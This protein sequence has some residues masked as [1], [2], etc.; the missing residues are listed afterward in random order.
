MKNPCRAKDTSL[1]S[2][3]ASDDKTFYDIESRIWTSAARTR[4]KS[5]PDFSAPSRCPSH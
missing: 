4:K 3:A 1:F 2:V 5:W